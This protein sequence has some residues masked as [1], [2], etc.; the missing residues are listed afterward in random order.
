MTLAPHVTIIGHMND[1][2][3]T[4]YR[5]ALEE[6]LLRLRDIAGESSRSYRTLKAYRYKQRAVPVDAA[7]ELA[8][9]LEQRSTRLADLAWRLRQ[10]AREAAGG[11]PT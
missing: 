7:L 4:A 10:V 3:G 6:A 8:E 5:I 1:P 11:E 2:L 9:A